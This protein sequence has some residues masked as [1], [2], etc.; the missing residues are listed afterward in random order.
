MSVPQI[1]I[2]SIRNQLR[3]DQ[4]FPFEGGFATEID[5]VTNRLPGDTHVVE[6]LRLMPL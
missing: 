5:Q 4:P 2:L 3:K 6:E 1:R